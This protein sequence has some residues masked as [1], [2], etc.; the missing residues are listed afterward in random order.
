M[1]PVVDMFAQND[2]LDSGDRLVIQFLEKRVGGRTGGAPFGCEQLD[3]DGNSI[4]I[5]SWR[6]LAGGQ[7]RHESDRGQHCNK[8]GIHAGT[9][10]KSRMDTKLEYTMPTSEEARW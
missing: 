5:R 10:G 4:L 3:Q 2:E 8:S 9:I 7:A 1:I 6:T